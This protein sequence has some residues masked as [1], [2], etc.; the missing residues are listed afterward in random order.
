MDIYTN[1]KELQHKEGDEAFEI[2]ILDRQSPITIVAPHGG[3]IELCTTELAQLIAG[4]N[5]NFYSFIARK[6]QGS[7]DLHI[8]SHNFDE[9]ACLALLKRSQQVVTVH[10][11]I[12][13]R[14]MIYLGGLHHE[15]IARISHAL[16]A[17]NLP[18]SY[19][20]PKYRGIHP[21]NICNRSSSGMGVQLEISL[22]LRRCAQSRATIADAI[23]EALNPYN[24]WLVKP[25][26]STI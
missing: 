6:N 19:D 2:A 21:D 5:F 7:P 24:N 25:D 20:H 22:H 15:L 13:D 10:G 17:K 23:Q 8:T 18:V 14:A 1:F 12:F 26:T 16:K 9:P 3:N 4:N 11:F